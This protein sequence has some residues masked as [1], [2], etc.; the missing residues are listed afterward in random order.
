MDRWPVA[1]RRH[2][3]VSQ[4]ECSLT[5]AH[6]SDA[7]VWHANH[8]A[9]WGRLHAQVQ[10]EQLLTVAAAPSKWVQP[11][12]PV[13]LH[14]SRERRGFPTLSA[15]IKNKAFVLAHLQSDKPS[16]LI[17]CGVMALCRVKNAKKLFLLVIDML[18]SHLDPAPDSLVKS[19]GLGCKIYFEW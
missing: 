10:S 16:S 2:P 12:T 4:S 19:K 17:Q 13:N 5:A 6:S 1:A 14:G 15:Q 3:L 9:D 11:V 18:I 8:S 7:A